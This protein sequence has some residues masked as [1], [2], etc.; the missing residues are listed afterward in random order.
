MIKEGRVLLRVQHLKQSARRITVVSAADLVDLIDEYQRVLSA[1]T[2]ERLNDLARQCSAQDIVSAC[3][4]SSRCMHT[5]PTY[6][7]L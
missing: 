2:F 1:Y 6:V 5:Y 3:K 4:I 7:R